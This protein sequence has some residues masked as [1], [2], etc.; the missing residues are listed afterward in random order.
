M[1]EHVGRDRHD[2]IGS[3]QRAEEVRITKGVSL[4]QFGQDSCRHTQVNPNGKDVPTP[5]PTA[6]ANDELV[7]RQTGRDGLDDGIRHGTPRINDGTPADLEH[8]RIR[9]HTEDRDFS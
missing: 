5:G 4:G 6:G 3:E 8:V 9:Q 7:R 2:S 1:P